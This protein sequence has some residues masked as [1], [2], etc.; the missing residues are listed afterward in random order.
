MTA[1]LA[2]SIGRKLAAS[3]VAIFCLTYL[4]TALFVFTSVR[5]SMTQSEVQA[6][7][8]MAGQKLE[9]VS[10]G[11]AG[12]ATN[13]RAWSQLD[14]MN[15]MISGDVDKRVAR[16]LDSLK[17]QY[18][19]AGA[20]YAFDARDRLVAGSDPVP[21]GAALPPAWRNEGATLRLSDKHRDPFGAG[22]LVVLSLALRASFAPD[23]RLGTLVV[24]LPWPSIE[25]ML[26]QQDHRVL[27]YG[28]ERPGV[29]YDGAGAGGAPVAPAEAARL[30][31]RPL[32]VRLGARRYVAGYS[33]Q[34]HALLNDWHVAALKDAD[35]AFAPIR[36]VALKLTGL[37]FL[38]ALPIVLAIGWL[39]RRLT[40]P[41]EGLT[42]VVSGITSAGDLER[43]ADVASADELGTLARTFNNM[44]ERLQRSSR[45][46]EM[47]VAELESL[48]KSLETR[49]QERTRAL[50]AANGELTGAIASLRAT[51]GQLV[52]SEKMASLGQLVAGV[53]HELNNPIGFIYANFP[54]LEEY[55]AELTGLIAALRALPLEPANRA[56][57][58]RLIA[59]ADLAFVEDDIVKI[60][61]SGKSGAAR[62]KEIVSS[63][64]SFSRLDEAELKSVLL[65]DGLR[66]TLAI[67]HHRI[68]H[69]VEVSLEFGLNEP[70]MCR[71]GQINQVFMNII[72]NALQAI[73]DQGALRIVTE[74][75]GEAAV[76]RV[77]DNGPGIAA[78][79][80]G[81]IFDPF[82][83]TKK[84]GEGTGLGLS[85]SY[86]IIEQHGG[87]LTVVS[88]SGAA[89]HGTE[90]TIRIPL[91]PA[92]AGAP[93]K[94]NP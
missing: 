5:A 59:A 35:L 37:G 55:A 50:E 11:V 85:I 41:I 66:D 62:I 19:L 7:R 67:L 72:Y 17:R 15:D 83:T 68:K 4:L 21:P 13:L 29:L 84:V 30:V 42:R 60:I 6:L 58:E 64:R 47:F 89:G 54:H 10:S 48:N 3:F 75:D 20:I 79:V 28:D 16:T 26:G 70:V 92:P 93:V 45:E 31:A 86:G 32:E 46:R 57:A 38:L 9:L 80:I 33:E 39:A 14:V 49:V 18:G 40:A 82:F 23:Y 78:E 1:W 63:L 24:T 61:R 25:Q 22:Q 91:R 12:L 51:Q 65:E 94:A 88:Q 74:R 43:R 69:G 2:R 52:Q 76:V 56:A 53:A 81:K 87:R 34:H 8:Q 73:A 36:A 71:A 90:F 44:A 77:A 27:L